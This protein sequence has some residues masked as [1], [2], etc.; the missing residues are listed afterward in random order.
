MNIK[1]MQEAV[2]LLKAGELLIYPTETFF[3]IGCDISNDKAVS[4][5]FQAKHRLLAMP[6]PIIVGSMDDLGKVAQLNKLVEKDVELLAEL[7]WPGA[8]T[9]ILPA[10][11]QISPLL[12][13]G[14]NTIAVR[15]SS[16]PVARALAEAVGPLVSS[17]ANISGRPAARKLEDLDE[18]LVTF[19][20]SV[21]NLPPEPG[22]GEPS[23]LVKPLGKFSLKML[24]EGAFSMQDIE[25]KGFSFVE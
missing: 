21:L 1:N 19:V 25:N 9:L 16:H 13:G 18:E 8:L 23:T 7:F 14:T 2:A 22:G 11:R 3:G 4:R 6:L 24:R 5:V 17:S 12:T 15:V 20:G 10:R